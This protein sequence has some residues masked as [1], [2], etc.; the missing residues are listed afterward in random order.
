[1]PDYGL[2]EFHKEF[3]GHCLYGYMI[4]SFF[5]PQM[6]VEQ[7]DQVDNDSMCRRSIREAGDVYAD[8]GG[9]LASQKL[10]DILK[11]VAA[12]GAI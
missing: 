12:M 6:L 2:E 3:V 10:A 7:K 1:L 9:E 8:L 4:C 5:L 11:H